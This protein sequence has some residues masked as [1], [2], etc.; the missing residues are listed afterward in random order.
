MAS[1]MIAFTSCPTCGALAQCIEGDPVTWRHF[2]PSQPGSADRDAYEGAREDLLEWKG[3]AQ[4]A[5]ARLRT[6]GWKGEDASEQPVSAAGAEGSEQLYYLQDTRQYVGN[7]PTWWAK[8]R[9][10]YVTR[11][12]HAHKFTRAE[13][14]AQAICRSTD[15][16]W[17][18]SAIDTILRP[19][20]DMQELRRLPKEST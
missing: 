16:P 1:D 11:L 6:L 19:T 14:I 3:R 17:L 15:R 2:K 18:C 12:D 7:C 5:E 9:M 4:R 10:G 8:D 20:V 13:A